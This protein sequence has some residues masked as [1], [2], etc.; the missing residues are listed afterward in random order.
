MAF[1]SDTGSRWELV[2][3]L[4]CIFSYNAGS[5]EK[6]AMVLL[7]PL[8]NLSWC[9]QFI[10]ISHCSHWNR[11]LFVGTSSVL[12]RRLLWAPRHSLTELIVHNCDANTDAATNHFHTCD[13]R[14]G[15]G[16]PSGNGLLCLCVCR[17]DPVCPM[18]IL[19]TF[20]QGRA[21]D[22]FFG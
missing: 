3:C 2:L 9:W 16:L 21:V 19:L 10:T 6:T 13:T 18:S 15:G 17:M 14:W 12:L 22:V 20:Q 8:S 11:L 1:V 5:K 7:A 4:C